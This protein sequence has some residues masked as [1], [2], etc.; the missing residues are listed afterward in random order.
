MGDREALLAAVVADP[1]ADLPRLVYAD[2][3]DDHGEPERAEFIRV[4]CELAR[5]ATDLGLAERE[6][7]LS[8]RFADHWRGQLQRPFRKKW[9]ERVDWERT[10]DGW[11]D[12]PAFDR[13]FPTKLWMKTAGELFDNAGVLFA[14]TPVR[15]LMVHSV[16]IAVKL[17]QPAQLRV[18]AHVPLPH[19]VQVGGRRPDR[20]PSTSTRYRTSDS[21]STG[22]L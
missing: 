20:L 17:S 19:P 22:R 10:A 18:A 1:D 6:G 16:M 8:N 21:R 4:Q 12:G 7:E 14:S 3:C 11:L 13:G 5:D 2:W 15:R 9:E